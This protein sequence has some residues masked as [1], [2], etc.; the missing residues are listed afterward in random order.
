MKFILFTPLIA[1]LIAA[2]PITPRA[3]QGLNLPIIDYPLRIEVGVPI[4][5]ELL[6]GALSSLILFLSRSNKMLATCT[7]DTDCAEDPDASKCRMA[8]GSD[9]VLDLGF[10]TV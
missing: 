3:P 8:P 5:D 10:C 1:V 6:M 7:D 2:S 9:G 4:A